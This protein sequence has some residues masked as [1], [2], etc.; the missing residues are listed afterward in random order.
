MIYNSDIQ[1]STKIEDT[2]GKDVLSSGVVGLIG[3]PVNIE[4][5]SVF[6][7]ATITFTYDDTLLGET[8]EEDL[9]VMWYDEETINTLLWMGKLY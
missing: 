2:Y 4:S 7:E 8:K 1:Y 9:R 3:V 6:D 5:T